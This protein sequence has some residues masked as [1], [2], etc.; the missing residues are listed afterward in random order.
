MSTLEVKQPCMSTLEVKETMH[1][2][3]RGKTIHACQL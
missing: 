2:D 3:F 1:V